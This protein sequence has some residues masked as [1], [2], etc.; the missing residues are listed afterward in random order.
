[1]ETEAMRLCK[2]LVKS[3][4][5]FSRDPAEY[6]KVKQEAARLLAGNK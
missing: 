5:K 4:S 1:M 6:Q 2:E 3:A